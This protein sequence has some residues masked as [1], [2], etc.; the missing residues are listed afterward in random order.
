MNENNITNINAT[1]NGQPVIVIDGK[2]YPIGYSTNTCTATAADIRKG[3]TAAVQGGVVTGTLEVSGGGGSGSFVKVTEFVPAQDAYETVNAVEVSGF[4]VAETWDGDTDF[5]DWNGTYEDISGNADLNAKI[6]KHTSQEKYLYR[7]YEP[8]NE[9]YNWQFANS[10]NTSLWSSY[11]SRSTLESGSW[12]SPYY[13]WNVDFYLTITTS[14]SSV[15]AVPLTLKGNSVTYSNGTWVEGSAVTLTSY[16][17][18][19]I[20]N[21]I[22]VLNGSALVGDAIEYVYDKWMPT[23]GLLSYFPMT[24]K[25]VAAADYVSKIKLFPRGN[26][27]VSGEDA[28]YGNGKGGSLV[29][30]I[31]KVPKTL[32]LSAKFHI[33]SWDGDYSNEIPVFQLENGFDVY[34]HRDGR[35]IV[36]VGGEYVDECNFNWDSDCVFFLSVSQ[37][38]I[39]VELRHYDTGDEYD[40][41]ITPVIEPDTNAFRINVLGYPEHM[42]FT[43][44]VWDIMLYD[45]VLEDYEKNI[46]AAHGR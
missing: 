6:F 16:T 10:P 18:E 42:T 27:V 3:K 19:P 46:I 33:Y 5:S 40:N 36:Y 41:S 12:S 44:K 20:T 17:N 9:E 11:F 38:G 35:F 21:G 30:A 4:G 25:A 34:L 26:G 13:D 23:N 15:S 31:S 24:G 1:T 28:W 22:Y 39:R 2:A 7:Y 14:T 43:G 32:T 8:D 45:R 29:G 37:Y